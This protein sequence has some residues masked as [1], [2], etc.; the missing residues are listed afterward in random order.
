MHFSMNGVEE[1]EE[2]NDKINSQDKINPLANSKK[3]NRQSYTNVN[4][5]T[6]SIKPEP[7]KITSQQD[8]LSTSMHHVSSML[9]QG[10]VTSEIS[11]KKLDSSQFDSM[12][13]NQI[14]QNY[15]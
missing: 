15:R 8:G 6:M 11:V 3:E 9:P 14:H 7:L 13:V 1:T 2:L 5:Q 4:P 10:L 12:L